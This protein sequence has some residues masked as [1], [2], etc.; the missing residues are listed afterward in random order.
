MLTTSNLHAYIIIINQIHREELILKQTF[1]A[2]V[3]NKKKKIIKILGI[4][5]F[6]WR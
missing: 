5:S 2:D 4:S 1:K 6:G 3:S